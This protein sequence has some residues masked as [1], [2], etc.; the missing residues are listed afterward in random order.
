MGR[1]FL[2]NLHPAHP[3]DRDT[4]C[5]DLQPGSRRSF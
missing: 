1:S 5:H 2:L 3:Q 4:Q